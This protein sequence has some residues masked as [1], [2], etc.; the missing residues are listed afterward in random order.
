MAAY[1]SRRLR[2]TL[3]MDAIAFE[4]MTIPALVLREGPE[5][6][7]ACRSGGR[8][9]PGST[10]SRSGRSPVFYGC[11]VP[12]GDGC[13]GGPRP[14]LPRQRLVPLRDPWLAGPDRLPALSSRA[15]GATRS[16]S[17]SS[18]TPVRHDR[19]GAGRHRPAGAPDRPQPRRHARALRGARR[20]ELV[21]SVSTLGSPFRGI[22]SHPLVLFASDRVR[23]P[24]RRRGPSRTAIPASAAA[25]R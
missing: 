7:A 14:G 5:A 11:G 13:G 9:W 20:P 8:R 12:R 18:P 1:H 6:G 19:N 22:R 23:E 10:G 15:W 16:A 24:V 3:A 2:V 4:H 21:A 25:R 17:T